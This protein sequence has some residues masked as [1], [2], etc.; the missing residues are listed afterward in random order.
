MEK[1]GHMLGCDIYVNE[2]IP[3]NEFMVINATPETIQVIKQSLI[4]PFEQIMVEI[5]RNSNSIH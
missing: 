5:D 1:I 4:A 2:A 3:D